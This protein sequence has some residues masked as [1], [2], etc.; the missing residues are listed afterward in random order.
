MLA[1]IETPRPGILRLCYGPT[2]LNLQAAVPDLSLQ[3]FF[4]ILLHSAYILHAPRVETGLFVLGE[5]LSFTR[6]GAS[7]T[8]QNLAPVPA[9]LALAFSG[10]A[11]K[12]AAIQLRASHR[13]CKWRALELT[14]T[15]LMSTCQPEQRA[16]ALP[17]AAPF[18]MIVPSTGVRIITYVGDMITQL[19]IK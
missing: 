11:S 7:C 6:L 3:Y 14:K 10:T 13:S 15:P 9:Y 2:V 18:R 8:A 1:R 16:C 4:R 12:N 17:D 5:R 19:V